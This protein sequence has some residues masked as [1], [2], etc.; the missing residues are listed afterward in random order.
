MIRSTRTLPAALVA[1]VLFALVLSGCS[2]S[3]GGST[4]APAKVRIGTLTTEDALPL[5]VAERDGLF[6]KAGL[7]VQIVTFQSAQERDAALTANA[8]DG[9]MGDIIAASAL[10]AGGVPVRITTIMLGATPKEGRFGIVAAPG[11][12]ITS[13][14]QLAGV[15]VATSS[16]TIQEYVIDGLMGQ[17]GIALDQVKK[18]EVKKVPVRFELLMSGKLKAAAL[19]EPLLSL[20]VKQGAVLV[21]DDT[22]GANLS[23]TVLVFAEKYLESGEGALAVERLLTVWDEAVAVVNKDPNAQRTLLVDKAR[24]P[25][26]L[27][28]DYQVNTYPLHQLPTKEQVSD[29]LEWMKGAG[30]LTKDIAYADLTWSAPA[31]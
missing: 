16:G 29:V 18:E 28:A 7:D 15:P 10:R 3:D 17:V 9:F 27:K 24:L 31:K 2:A 22:E 6:K 13:L 8:I 14:E 5:W 19:P 21:A 23:Q 20:A 1:G 26:P 11:S 12:T 25:E 4:A 30:L